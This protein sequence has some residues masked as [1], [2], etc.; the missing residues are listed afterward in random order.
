MAAAQQVIAAPALHD[1]TGMKEEDA[2]REMIPADTPCTEVEEEQAHHVEVSNNGGSTDEGDVP[3]MGTD[4][5]DQGIVKELEAKLSTEHCPVEAEA[6]EPK[7]DR[8]LRSGKKAEKAAAKGAVVPVD[9]ET[10]DDEVAATGVANKTEKVAAKGA[11]VPV[12]FENNDDEVAVA[13]VV[14]KKTEKTAVK[15]AVV[16]VD[17]EVFTPANQAPAIAPIALDQEVVARSD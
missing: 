17:N 1:K 3:A 9:F 14:G 16:P 15:G 6:K 12:D 2:N 8:R 13:A 10:D 7:E 11:V 4:D 5:Q